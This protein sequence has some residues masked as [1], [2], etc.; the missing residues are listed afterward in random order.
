MAWLRPILPTAEG[1]TVF[2]WGLVGYGLLSV[3]VFNTGLLVAVSQPGRLIV[4]L[5]SAVVADLIV[6]LL[7]AQILGYEASVLGLVAGATVLLASSTV[8]VISFLKTPAYSLY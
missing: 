3:A 7:A 6:A 1:L 5:V 2:R 8:Q 4:P